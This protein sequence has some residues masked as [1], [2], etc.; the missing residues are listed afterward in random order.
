[1]PN[2]PCQ[3]KQF[4][5]NPLCHL[6][7]HVPRKSFIV[8]QFFITISDGNFWWQFLT[9]LNSLNNFGQFFAIGKAVPETWHLRHWLQF[10]QLRTWIQSI[11][12]TWQLIVTLDSIRNSCDVFLS[13]A[14]FQLHISIFFLHCAELQVDVWL[15]LCNISNASSFSISDSDQVGNH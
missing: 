12:L 2:S 11:I 13:F 15:M 8:C 14:I 4:R 1:M 10:W 5:T 9:I 7:M 3:L 6:D